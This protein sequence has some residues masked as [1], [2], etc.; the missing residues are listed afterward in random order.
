MHNILER[1]RTRRLRLHPH[2]RFRKFKL[3]C[4]RLQKRAADCQRSRFKL[5][6]CVKHCGAGDNASAAGK[7]AD[8]MTDEIGIP[9]NDIDL[10]EGDGELLRYNLSERGAL[11]LPLRRRAHAHGGR[12]IKL[13]GETH[14]LKWTQPSVF[15]AARDAYANITILGMRLALFFPLFLVVENL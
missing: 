2:R 8:A 13:E 9:G 12:S 4:G 5:L 14:F 6:T 15:D 10:L 3:I 1:Y 7:R 11:A